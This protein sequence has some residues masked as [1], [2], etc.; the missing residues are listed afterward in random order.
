MIYILISIVI[1][2]AILFFYLNTKSGKQFLKKQATSFLTKKL[3]TK[4][5]IESIDFR[6]PNYFELNQV[7]IEDQQ[8]DSLFYGEQLTVNLALFK[9]IQGETDI[10]KIALSNAAI[11]IERTENDSVF[12]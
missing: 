4:L 9:L 3:N 1:L 10:K 7:M 5:S 8:H 2:I 12:N 11:H 6:L